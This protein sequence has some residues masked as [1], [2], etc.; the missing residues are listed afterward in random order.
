MLSTSSR[1]LDNPP[2][3]VGIERLAGDLHVGREQLPRRLGRLR[4]YK[5][6]GKGRDSLYTHYSNVPAKSEAVNR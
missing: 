6:F 5:I 4:L 2:D 3:M 1:G